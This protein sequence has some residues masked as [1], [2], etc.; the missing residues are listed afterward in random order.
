MI[1]FSFKSIV[2]DHFLPLDTNIDLVFFGGVVRFPK[3]GFN[4]SFL[5]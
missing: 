2:Q 5:L 4:L 3:T 1:E